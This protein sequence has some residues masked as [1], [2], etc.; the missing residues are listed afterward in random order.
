MG[1]GGIQSRHSITMESRNLQPTHL[2]YLDSLATPE[3]LDKK[4]E[5]FTKKG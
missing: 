2:G 5:V 1:T 3:C 4:T